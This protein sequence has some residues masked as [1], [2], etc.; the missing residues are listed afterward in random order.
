[1]IVASVKTAPFKLAHSEAL[2]RLK[3]VKSQPLRLLPSNTTPLRFF[4]CQL[5]VL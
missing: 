3:P 5:A 1:M 2:V 4:A